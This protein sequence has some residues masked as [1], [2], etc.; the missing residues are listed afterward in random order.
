MPL[1]RRLKPFERQE[2]LG[3]AKLRVPLKD[4][5]NRLNIAYS[6]VK[7]TKQLAER[8]DQEQHDLPRS[9]R[10]RKST[11]AQDKRLIRRTHINTSLL[12]EELL[13]STALSKSTVR[14]RF[15]E[16]DSD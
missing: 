13:E 2:I 12:W 3:A 5:S 16:L 1:Q 14:R 6:T 10:P 9:G 7:Y 11:K 8:R 15:K 4:I